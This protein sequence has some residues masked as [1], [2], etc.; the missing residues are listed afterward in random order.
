MTDAVADA[1][2]PVVAMLLYPGVTDIDVVGPRAVLAFDMDVHLVWKDLDRVVSDSGM[3]L[4]PTTTLAECPQDVDVLMIPGGHGTKDVMAD[5]EVLE[6][7]ADMASR[8]RYVTSVCY[9]SIVLGAAGLLDGYRAA[10]HWAARE[11][12]EPFGAQ[13]V[14]E[15]VV[16]D[17]NRITGG[18]ATAGMDF[19]LAVL[20][21]LLGDERAQAS[22]LML[23]YDPK[24]PFDA[25]AP[26]RAPHHVVDAIR[27]A[28]AEPNRAIVQ[29]TALIKDKGWGKAPGAVPGVGQSLQQSSASCRR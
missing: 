26:E 5:V 1:R 12:L 10:T 16:V 29:Q 2:R 25:G 22:Q 11:L 8:A 27:A 23:E 14:T 7:I 9:G 13:N 4:L 3:A 28:V 21:E 18:G 19:G 15:R 24:P 20:A 17:R 6:W